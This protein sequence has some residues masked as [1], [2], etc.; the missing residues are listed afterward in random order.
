MLLSLAEW[1]GV[2]CRPTETGCGYSQPRERSTWPNTS[3]MMTMMYITSVGNLWN[4]STHLHLSSLRIPSKNHQHGAFRDHPLCPPNSPQNRL[5][6]T[7]RVHFFVSWCARSISRGSIRTSRCRAASQERR[8]VLGNSY[9]PSHLL[10]FLL[11]TVNSS[12]VATRFCTTHGF[13]I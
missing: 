11:L 7:A 2:P 1:H 8:G 6:Q 3:C 9:V 10:H 12:R 5:R 4:L 13:L